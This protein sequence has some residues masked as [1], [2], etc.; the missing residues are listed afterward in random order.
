MRIVRAF[1]MRWK[2]PVSRDAL[3]ER[4]GTEKQGAYAP[5]SPN[6]IVK[7]R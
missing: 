1:W 4:G 2:S 3:A 7:K 5:R 6:V